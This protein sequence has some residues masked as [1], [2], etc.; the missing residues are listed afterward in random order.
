MEMVKP[1]LEFDFMKYRTPVIG[2]LV[3]L[4]TASLIS[5]FY[6]GPKYGIDFAGG[7]EVQIAFNGDVKSSE[8]RDALEAR[9]Y[10]RP[11]VVS[12]EGAPNEYIIR[13]REVSSLDD[14]QIS[15]LEAAATAAL[16]ESAI[17]K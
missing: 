7:T 14:A 13:V 11:D 8:I 17:E 2:V 9:G 15:K 3:F 10:D 6:P 4:A 12:V 5:L 1:G 16:G